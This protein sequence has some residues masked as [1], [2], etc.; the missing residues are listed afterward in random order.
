MDMRR[1]HLIS[2]FL[3]NGGIQYFVERWNEVKYERDCITAFLENGGWSILFEGWNE[4]K[5]ETAKLHA[6]EERRETFYKG[7]TSGGE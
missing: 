4:V 2:T 3:E 1:I 5:Y 6:L 7:T